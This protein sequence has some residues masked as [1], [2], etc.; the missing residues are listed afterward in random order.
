MLPSS[1]YTISVA[2]ACNIVPYLAELAFGS[3][4]SLLSFNIISVPMRKFKWS[5]RIDDPSFSA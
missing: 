1:L 2:I 3:F 5:L 4:S